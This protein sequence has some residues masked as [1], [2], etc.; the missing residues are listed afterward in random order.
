MKVSELQYGDLLSPKF[1]EPNGP[2]SRAKLR[3]IQTGLVMFG[4]IHKECK[5]SF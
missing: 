3:G 4:R 1:D 5:K 2:L